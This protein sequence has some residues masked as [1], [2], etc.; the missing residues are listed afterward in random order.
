MTHL[1]MWLL[2]G[3]LTGFLPFQLAAQ[4]VQDRPELCGN[5]E[6]ATP[7]PLGISATKFVGG[8]DLTIKLA[9]HI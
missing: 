1:S 8:V 2:I 3:L 6:K 5:V 9:K 4:I 7:V